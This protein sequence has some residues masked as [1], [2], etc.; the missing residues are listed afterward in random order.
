MSV[1]I[2]GSMAF[3]SVE[4]PT[5]SRE[6][7]LG[8]SA[9]YCSFA[10]SFFGS[11]RLVSVV[12]RD[13]PE[14][15]TRLLKSRGVETSGLIVDPDDDTFRWRGRYAENMNDRETIDL[16]LNAY[17]GFDPN[18]S[19]EFC[20]TPF[21]FLAN[22]IPAIQLKVLDQLN[23]TRLIIADTH[24]D[25]F[26]DHHADLMKVLQRVDGLALNESEATLLTGE[27][28]P[29]TAG[30]KLLTMGPRF[31]VIKQGT[32]GATFVSADEA[33]SLPAYRTG[34]VVDPTG[35]GDT[36]AGGLMGRLAS[37][38]DTSSAAIK[39]AIE[40]GTVIASFTVEDFSLDR[41]QQIDQAQLDQR[42]TE[43]RS[44]A[45]STAL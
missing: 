40:H 45:N 29:V 9:V 14:E 43:Y 7:L 27:V 39:D 8:G 11:V 30:R 36:F 4:T 35:A 23:S 38:D 21:V 32:E 3:D 17:E 26:A 44:Q 41:L 25:W 13:W 19:P 33:Y 31:A 22:L 24:A 6:N 16:Q 2:V 5:T 28:D 15:F 42:L 20:A 18:L 37:Q 12:G 34:Q 10:A 1:L